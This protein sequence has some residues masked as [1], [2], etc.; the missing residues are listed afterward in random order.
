MNFK[1]VDA[2][3]DFSF[4]HTTLADDFIRCKWWRWLYVNVDIAVV[5][6]RVWWLWVSAF[7]NFIV[8][9]WTAIIIIGQIGHTLFVTMGIVDFKAFDSFNV[10][11]SWWVNHL[12]NVHGYIRIHDSSVSWVDRRNELT[13][14]SI[15]IVWNI[16]VIPSCGTE[17]KFLIC[18]CGDRMG[19]ATCYLVYQNCPLLPERFLSNCWRWNYSMTH[20][21]VPVKKLMSSAKHWVDQQLK[22]WVHLIGWLICLNQ[23]IERLNSSVVSTQR[24]F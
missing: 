22:G 23:K 3:A 11:L 18:Q 15:Q 19:K 6:G 12:L 9:S 7:L 4:S 20:L 14:F 16:G 24:G 8:Y 17:R 1:T 21:Q 10:F 13:K 2:F 5:V